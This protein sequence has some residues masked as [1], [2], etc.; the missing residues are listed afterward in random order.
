MT[1]P[2]ALFAEIIKEAQTGGDETTPGAL[3]K[4]AATLSNPML[5]WSDSTRAGKLFEAF[6]SEFG[7]I[8]LAAMRNQ[9]PAQQERAKWIGLMRWLNSTLA[10]W[11]QNADPDRRTLTALF[12]AMLS[13]GSRDVLDALPNT[14]GNNADIIDV[15][16]TFVGNQSFKPTTRKGAVVP[17]WEAEAVAAFQTADSNRD[18]VAIAEG[19]R[20]L[21][22]PLLFNGFQSLAVRWLYR[23]RK[24]RLIEAAAAISQTPV[25]FLLAHALRSEERLTLAT[26]SENPFVQFACLYETLNENRRVS[27]V[28]PAEELLICSI[29]T[30]TATDPPRWQAWMEV[31]N[32]YPLR[33]PVLQ[34]PLGRALAEVTDAACEAYVNSINLWPSRVGQDTSRLC[35]AECLREFRKAGTAA[36]QATLW[37]L[38]F[39]RWK[40]WNFEAGNDATHVFEIS[41]CEIDYAVMGYVVECMD[42]A[43]RA[44]TIADINSQIFSLD[45][46]WHAS[47]SDFYSAFNRLLS[48]LQPYLHADR[49]VTG[50]DWLSEK[51]FFR[52]FDD[53]NAYARMIFSAR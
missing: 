31:F 41:W 6:E 52:I 47:L 37:T 27:R 20:M 17:V 10:S 2:A 18:W 38:A 33:F 45:N 53:T 32:K 14:V 40:D 30:A 19:W 24:D 3:L 5:A 42:A 29:L 43:A 50:T 13:L 9:L 1:T 28:S 16:S 25:A 11:S 51:T 49:F 12:V 21:D 15:L 22:N 7:F 4:E 35:V 23:F 48:A 39:K 8:R 46:C 26:E 44:T 36:R 34:I